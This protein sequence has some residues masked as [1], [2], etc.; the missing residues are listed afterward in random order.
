MRKIVFF[1]TIILFLTISFPA[2]AQPDWPEEKKKVV[3][4][5]D[6]VVDHDY[7]AVGESVTI[8]G[9]VN[10]DVFVGAGS[11]FVDGQINGDLIAGAGTITLVGEVSQDV[12]V[13]GGTVSIQGVVGQNV[14]VAGG[15]ISITKDAFIG[16]NVLAM[17]GNVET[18]GVISK[19]FQA[20]GGK[21]L[22]GGNIGRDVLGE[23]GELVI[24]PKITIAG[25]LTY[26]SPHEVYFQNESTVAG[27]IAYTQSEKKV[28]SEIDWK[29]NLKSVVSMS[30]NKGFSRV[31]K[32]FKV[33]GF[34]IVFILGLVFMKVFPQGT[35]KV[36]KTLENQ[37]WLS[38]G[39]GIV[40]PFLFI[41]GVVLLMISIIGIPLGLL[42]MPIFGF[43]VYFSKIFTALFVG[44]KV[45]LS[46]N[47]NERR[48]WALFAGLLV[49]CLLK[50][51]PVVG[52][53][54]G[55]AFTFFGLGAL[56][57]YQKSIYRPAK[58]KRK[59]V[60]KK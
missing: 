18:L 57:L 43:I 38:L 4:E 49:F 25:D 9:V 52:F 7:F 55:L 23:M 6:E 31:K 32:N 54:S 28:S 19:D 48:G 27:E 50:L 22:L 46:L 59:R 37:S 14:T 33:F 58:A 51:V 45:L 11:I 36:V 13:G 17:G 47:M 60:P 2:F 1:L 5:I 35:M 10:G 56:V 20:Y 12:R 53:F 42:L 29:P 30:Q 24:V 21:V 34:M 44:R 26:K 40:V 39:V 3:L 15:N 41:I 8:S 16:G